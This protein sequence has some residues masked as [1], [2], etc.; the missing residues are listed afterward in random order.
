MN[1]AT[2]KENPKTIKFVNDNFIEY[3]PFMTRV[4]EEC[5]F[6]AVEC[7]YKNKDFPD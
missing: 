7:Y 5:P 4:I 3:M 2:K 6:E 1:K